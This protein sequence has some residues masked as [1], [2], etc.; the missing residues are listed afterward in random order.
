MELQLGDQQMQLFVLKQKSTEEASVDVIQEAITR[1]DQVVAETQ[2]KVAKLFEKVCMYE[3]QST[4]VQPISPEAIQQL[5]AEM[6]D[7]LQG[8]TATW[9][10]RFNKVV[11][12]TTRTAESMEQRNCTI[13]GLAN[14]VERVR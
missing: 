5:R 2:D 13:V 11:G 8:M 4:Q 12:A 1:V 10:K 3:A 9:D 6:E 14:Q 7:K